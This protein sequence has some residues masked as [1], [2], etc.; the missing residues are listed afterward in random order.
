MSEKKFSA[1]LTCPYCKGIILYNGLDEGK[2]VVTC[3]A[4]E[5]G[6]DEDYVVNVR[7]V[8]ETKVYGIEGAE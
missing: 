4:D 5:G 7:I 3:D 8:V 6:C 1:I 2:Q